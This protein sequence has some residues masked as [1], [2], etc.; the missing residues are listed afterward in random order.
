MFNRNRKNKKKLK[1]NSSGIGDYDRK[2]FK[3]EKVV[4]DFN[5]EEETYINLT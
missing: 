4:V 5:G 2:K 3:I 1:K